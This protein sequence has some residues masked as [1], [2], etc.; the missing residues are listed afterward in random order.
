MKMR[1]C[2]YKKRIQIY[3]DGWMD[4]KEAGRLE[5]H[6]R[7]CSDCQTEMMELEEISS[8]A[9][10]IVDQAPDVNYWRN[11]PG[12][13]LNR[14]ISRNVSPYGG[15]SKPARS[16]RLKIGSYSVAVTALAVAVLMIFN[17]VN[18]S[19]VIPDVDVQNDV[20]V[21]RPITA[22]DSAEPEVPASEEP[23]EQPAVAESES[24]SD[25]Q[26]DVPGEERQL[27]TSESGPVS[28]DEIQE[29]VF[30][31]PQALSVSQ[32]DYDFSEAFRTTKSFELAPLKLD[33][34]YN[35]L[36]RLMAAYRGNAANDY[37]ISEAVVVEGILSGYSFR[38]IDGLNNGGYGSPDSRLIPGLTGGGF[39]TG[40]GYLSLP[41][42][43]SDAEELRKYLIEL[44]LMQAK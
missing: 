1:E 12:R 6:L 44:E 27:I 3:L 17:Y 19:D 33:E 22:D 29:S 36:N 7:Q 35:F 41:D 5:A 31:P 13:V 38:D 25:R 34:D 28:R 20:E 30:D 32:P 24:I 18:R 11:F 15:K 16:L 21:S 14:I 8:A 40:W 10:Q 42:N 4:D 37:R 2:E 26:R 39:S 23:R 9:L 43:A